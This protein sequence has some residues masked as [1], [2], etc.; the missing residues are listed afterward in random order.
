MKK[1]LENLWF[2]YLIEIPIARS[3]KEKTII[4]NWS[5]KEKYFRSILNEEQIKAFNE[6]DNALSM[7][8]RISE[9]NAFVKGVM[10]ATQ[11]L[12]EALHRE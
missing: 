6:Y 12:F 8:S 10:F 4:N 9:K 3:E 1:Y 11:F 5:E 7:V 2:N